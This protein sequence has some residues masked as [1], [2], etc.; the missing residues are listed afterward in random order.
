MTF[1]AQR[2]GNC[3][4]KFGGSTALFASVRIHNNL[5]PFFSNHTKQQG[6]AEGLAPIF[7]GIGNKKIFSHILAHRYILSTCMMSISN[8]EL[9]HVQLLM[10]S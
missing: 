7:F 4:P 5:G 9:L 3:H 1:F 10:I 2:F 6:A 8:H